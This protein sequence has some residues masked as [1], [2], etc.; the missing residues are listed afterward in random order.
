MNSLKTYISHLQ[1]SELVPLDV[2]R[3]QLERY[4][5]E[6]G[7]TILTD[8]S[9]VT[10]RLISDG[11]VTHWQNKKLLAGKNR[12]FFLGKY[13]ILK[14][15]G[16]GGM[17]T[18]YLAE[19]TVL[20]QQRA[21]KVLAK[22]FIDRGNYLNRFRNEARA[23]AGLNHK[24]IVQAFDFDEVNGTY[25]LVMEYFRGI[26][27]WEFVAQKGVIPFRQA[28]NL[29]C[30]AATGL[31]HAHEAGLV[32]RD[33]KPA[34]LLFDQEGTVKVLDL[35]LALFKDDAH[36]LTIANDDR[37]IGTTDFLAPE[38]AID[39]HNVDKRVDVYGLGC[40]LYFCLT[41]EVPFPNGSAAER[42]L[43]HQIKPIPNIR[44][45]RPDCP[46]SLD[47]I[48]QAMTP[49]KNRRAFARHGPG[50]Q[51]PEWLCPRHPYQGVSTEAFCPRR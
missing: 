11:L 7:Q 24:N 42:I 8:L 26:N 46:Q 5:D 34:N 2:L 3:H 16:T 1:K 22:K 43:A 27:L 40:T 48:C 21:I 17:S 18:V 32:H 28:A 19:H 9:Y 12:G 33:V 36:S 38:Q 4:R 47:T 44:D 14:H 50:C 15:L 45:K 10:E 31:H 37:V 49:K 20:R 23:I 29:L 39:S 25:F 51:I 41:G 6:S 35:G 30:Q 13:K